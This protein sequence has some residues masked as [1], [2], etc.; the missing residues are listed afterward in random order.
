V[1]VCHS[2]ARVILCLLPTIS[3]VLPAV[4]AVMLKGNG[5]EVLCHT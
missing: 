4:P 1:R 2:N 3:T 5:S